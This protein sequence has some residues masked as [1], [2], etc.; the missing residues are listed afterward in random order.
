MDIITSFYRSVSNSSQNQPVLLLYFHPFGHKTATWPSYVQ[1]LTALW[2]FTFI[3]H[4]SCT[5]GHKTATTPSYVQILTALWLF[6]FIMYHSCTLG[7]K[8]A[9]T[10]SYV[11]ILTTLWLFT[12]I[13]HHS[14]TLGHF[15]I[16]IPKADTRYQNTHY[17]CH[18]ACFTAQSG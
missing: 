13:M 16:Q 17:G 12:F 14:C 7:H 3:M 9:T 4:H 10:P 8:T 18:D 1:I 11:Q 5:L 2:L 6:T 15:P